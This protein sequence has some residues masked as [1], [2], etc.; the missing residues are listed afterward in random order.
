MNK[1]ISSSIIGCCLLWQQANAQLNNNGAS[2]VMENGAYLVIDNID[3]QN[4]GTFAQSAG[5]VLFTGNSNS[6]ISGANTLQ[7]YNLALNK[8]GASLLL[9]N[10]IT[11]NNE[12]S[13][14][15]GLLNLNNYNITLD[16]AASLSGESETSRITGTTGGY[17]QITTNLNAPSGVNAGNL[18]A[19]ITSTQN[20]GSTIIRRGHVSQVNG[21]GMGNSVYR[22]YDIIPAN[23]TALNATLYFNYFDAEL[24]SLTE[25]T[26]IL[27]T[28]PDNTTWTGQGFAVR[29]TITNW[30]TQSG[31]ANFARVTLTS[32]LNALP[33]IWSAFNTACAGNGVS[34]S[35]KTLQESNTSAFYVRRSSNGTSWQTIGTLP[36]VGNSN[37]AINYS[38][39]DP[40]SFSGA[41]YRIV[42]EDK[43]GIQSLSPVLQSRCEI[44]DGVSVYPNPAGSQCW[45]SVQSATNASVVMRLYD[46]KG[47]LVKQQLENVQAGSNQ[48]GFQMNGLPQGLYNLVIGWGSG[49]VKTVKIEKR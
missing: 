48:I 19:A 7:F 5:T 8:T 14:T 32:P 1:I 29:N 40:L 34:I 16:A 25:N 3:L 43:N 4:N 10:H 28:S 35:W 49:K 36:A 22:Y 17:V 12:L 13:F 20:L 9:Q 37:V 42:Q 15:N 18:G 6:N 33:L 11:V 23:N 47:L 30:V 24:N 38:F 31:F 45:V 26:L 41:M 21:S 44:G 39:T 2:I 46:S 27:A